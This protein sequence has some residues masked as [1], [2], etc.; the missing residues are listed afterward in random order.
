[1]TVATIEAFIE[2]IRDQA[3]SDPEAFHGNRDRML[4]DVLTAIAKGATGGSATPKR[5]AIA[6]LKVFEIKPKWEACA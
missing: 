5:L 6:T 4:R 2:E 1:M 3:Q